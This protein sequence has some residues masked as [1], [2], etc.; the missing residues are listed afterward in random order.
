MSSKS[1]FEFKF[2]IHCG[3][4]LPEKAE[5]CTNC[6]AINNHLTK[7]SAVCVSCG[8]KLPFRAVYCQKCGTPVDTAKKN[9]PVVAKP[10]TNSTVC[11]CLYCGK[12]IAIQFG[13]ASVRC[14]HCDRIVFIDDMLS[15]EET[16]NDIHEI[17]VEVNKGKSPGISHDSVLNNG[18]QNIKQSTPQYFQ[19][20]IQQ[21]IRQNLQQDI[22]QN[23]QH[24]RQNYDKKETS[25]S[26]AID[27]PNIV[28][29]GCA[30][31][32]VLI[33]AFSGGGEPK[34]E[35]QKEEVKPPVVTE[36][37]PK[38]K[39]NVGAA[40]IEYLTYV[41]NSKSRVFHRENCGSVSKMKENNK[42]FF[43]SRDKAFDSGYKPCQ[44]CNP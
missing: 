4:R 27:I 29:I 18:I 5:S 7:T 38:P 14:P 13:T 19:H 43:S 10:N 28:I 30:V 40:K 36:V 12:E 1:L 34:K 37:A 22:Q 17:K 35:I 32:L 3:V 15:F 42:V 16:D 23:N 20:N 2:C 24:N 44:R 25:S 8:A 26:P 21:N 41:G 33:Y 39:S 31:I 11:K 6:G 9:D